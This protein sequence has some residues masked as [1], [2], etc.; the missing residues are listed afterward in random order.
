MNIKT[1]LERVSAVFW[2]IPAL[3]MCALGVAI[4]LE[5]SGQRAQG[6]VLI[7]GGILVPFVAHKI[8]CWIIAGFFAPPSS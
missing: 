1:G 5:S 8:T 2:C 6:G 4:L 3:A 7:L